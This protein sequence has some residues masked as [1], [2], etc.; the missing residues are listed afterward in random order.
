[1]N[2]ENI[3]AKQKLSQ[4]GKDFTKA[5][6]NAILT[7]LNTWKWIYNLADA[8]DKTLSKIIPDNKLEWSKIKEWLKN[9]INFTKNN[10]IKLLL[11]WSI[12]G[13]SWYKTADAIWWSDQNKKAKIEKKDISKKKIVYSS[14]EKNTYR[15][16]ESF[17]DKD[18]NHKI[19]N[20]KSIEV[21]WNWVTLLHDAWLTFYLMIP[22]DVQQKDSINSSRT[23]TI[24]FIKKKLS[25]IPQFSYLNGDS[26]TPTNNVVLWSFNIRPDYKKLAKNSK[27]NDHPFWIPIPVKKEL[28]EIE[29][30]SF[31]EA[32]NIAQ[33]EIMNYNKEYGKIRDSITK[34]Y[35]EKEIS[36]L[37]TAIALV[38]TWRTSQKIGYDTYHRREGWSHKCFSFGPQHILMENAWL[39]SR[40]KLSLTE[41]QMYH[42]INSNMVVLWFMIEKIKERWIKDKNKITKKLINLLDFIDN[43]IIVA[44]N[45]SLND[46]C[47]FYNGWTY[48][49]N[50][51]HTKLTTA[52]NRLKI[53][54]EITQNKANF[55]YENIDSKWNNFIYSYK[56]DLSQDSDTMISNK[57]II[58]KFKKA[59][60][61]DTDSIQVTRKNWEIFSDKIRHKDGQKVYIKVPVLEI[62]N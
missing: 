33:E 24:N 15:N 22:E 21:L 3:T 61:I 57:A 32:W 50:K 58:K 53:P 18:L 31:L 49:T 27:L 14:I 51:Y 39:K 26:Y 28:R 25:N 47:K 6:K 16:Q 13:Y 40:K 34:R 36:Q 8:W 62:T 1:M 43:D 20:N 54:K 48:K 59:Y 42:P 7:T 5:W 23:N 52:L 2:K 45:Q 60:N 38:E 9:T 44:N 17:F 4:A 41:W 46:F 12:L 19:S 29:N 56:I 37:L 11:V 55:T 30:K 10:I 35:W